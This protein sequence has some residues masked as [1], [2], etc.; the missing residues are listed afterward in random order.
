MQ[1]DFTQIEVVCL[2]VQPLIN[3]MPKQNSNPEKINVTLCP[4]EIDDLEK[5][6]FLA[7]AY[8]LGGV[9]QKDG[10]TRFAWSPD[11]LEDILGYAAAAA[12]HSSSRKLE[13]RLEALYEKLN[14][15]FE[16]YE[17]D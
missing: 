17:L 1:I 15:A 8:F 16:S 13:K 11:E 9:V 5:Y 6:A 2:P 4:Q 10:S 7:P 3:T 14:N 12:N